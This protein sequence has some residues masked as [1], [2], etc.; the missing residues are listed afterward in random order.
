MHKIVVPMLSKLSLE[1]PGCWYKHVSKVQQIIKNTEPRRTKVSPFKLLTG[2]D[3]RI[4][5]DVLLKSLIQDCLVSEL[6]DERDKLS[7]EA[8]ENIQSIQ[9]ENKKA[10]DAKRKVEKKFQLNDLVAIKRTQYGTGLKLKGKYLGPYKVVKV[11]NH[12]SYEVE[13]VGEGDGP[14]KKSIVAEY[15]K[16]FGTNPAEGGPIVGC[17]TGETRTT[18]SGLTY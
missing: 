11:G 6:D 14:Y 1:S 16:A 9:A 18:R 13:K 2:L 17:G 7:K 10:F 8:R 15:M 3:M 12:G 5:G 4:S